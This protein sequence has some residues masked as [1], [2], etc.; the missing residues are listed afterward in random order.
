MTDLDNRTIDKK[1]IEDQAT[2]NRRGHGVG[3]PGPYVPMEE[4]GVERAGVEE[5]D[6]REHVASWEVAWHKDRAW[7]E[8]YRARQSIQK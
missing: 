6:G 1:L 2:V 3:D 5:W 8:T 7:R 4:Y